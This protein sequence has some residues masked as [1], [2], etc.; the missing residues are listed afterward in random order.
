MKKT[1]LKFGMYAGITIVLLFLLS[2]TLLS[3]LSFSYQEII[4]Y[5]SMIISLSFV[6]I[7]IKS[8][9][10]KELGGSISFGKALGLGML[11]SLVPALLFGL[12]DA[13]YVAFIYPEFFDEYYVY[14][15]QEYR[16][17]YSGAELAA[18][19]DQMNSM[20]GVM[21]T[22]VATFILMFIT[23]LLLGFVMSLISSFA[24]RKADK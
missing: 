7:G 17:E 19:L 2:Y 3:D 16:A 5:T 18:K 14:M 9:R 23:V 10:D 22:P 15:E 6:F 12:F 21:D 1:V 13:V 4:G 11:I 20:K 8:Y 24:L